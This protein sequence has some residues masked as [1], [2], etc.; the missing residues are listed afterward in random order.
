MASACSN[1]NT[2]AIDSLP[3]TQGSKSPSLATPSPESSSLPNS[4][5]SSRPH[6]QYSNLTNASGSPSEIEKLSNSDETR[7]PSS[8]T[9]PPPDPEPNSPDPCSPPA[10]NAQHTMLP[11]TSNVSS[12]HSSQPVDS[13]PYQSLLTRIS[14]SGWCQATIGIIGLALTTLALRYCIRSDRMARWQMDND[15]LQAC[16]GFAQVGLAIE[17]QQVMML[18]VT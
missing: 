10:H 12:N 1:T 16:L 4:A 13:S 7:C 9:P 11:S 6:S 8:Q 5:D 3:L 14:W 18:T 2:I 15:E 17:C